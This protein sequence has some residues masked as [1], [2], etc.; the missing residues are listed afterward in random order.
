[1]NERCVNR[2]GPR[3][4]GGKRIRLRRREGS[5][6]LPGRPTEPGQAAIQRD[7]RPATEG[8]QGRGAWVKWG[9][10]RRRADCTTGRGRGR[11]AREAATNRGRRA[12]AWALEELLVQRRSRGRQRGEQ[13]LEETGDGG[14]GERREFGKGEVKEG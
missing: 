4:R 8:K 6:V 10:A 7:C 11:S 1:M 14:D 3:T 12:R 5:A 13:G 2:T 9:T